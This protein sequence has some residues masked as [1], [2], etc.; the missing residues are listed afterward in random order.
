MCGIIGLSTNQSPAEFYDLFEKLLIE[1]SIRGRHATGMS[2]PSGGKVITI[3]DRVPAE[4]FLANHSIRDRILSGEIPTT[5]IAHVRYC[6]SGEEY[7]QPIATDD[8]SIVHNGVVTQAD[9]S[10]WT[11]QFNFNDFTTTNDTELLL[12]S[13]IFG[14]D[15]LDQFPEASIAAISLN[16]NGVISF[17]RNGKRPVWYSNQQ[18]GTVIASTKDILSRCGI[19]NITKSRSMVTYERGLNKVLKIAKITSTTRKDLQE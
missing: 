2:F 19:D 3:K 6:T 18:Y 8:M 9:V 7:P 1:S 5:V 13:L 16:S 10:Q 14:N 15:P 4:D 17:F 11:E 12:K